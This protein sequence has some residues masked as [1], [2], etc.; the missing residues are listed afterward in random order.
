M[1]VENK[2]NT[3][4]CSLRLTIRKSDAPSVWLVYVWEGRSTAG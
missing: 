2:N 1:C 3:M 4:G